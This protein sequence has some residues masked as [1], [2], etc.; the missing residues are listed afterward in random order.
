MPLVPQKSRQDGTIYIGIDP[1][2]SGGIVLIDG[3]NIYVEPMPTTEQDTWQ[4]IQGIG[5]RHGKVLDKVSRS[6][7]PWY[8]ARHAVIEWIHPAIQGIGKSQMS[9]L[10]GNYMALRMALTACSI[11]FDVVMP[12]KWQAALNIQSRK[13]GEATNKWKDRLRAKAQQLH[14]GLECWKWNLGEQRKVSD[15]VLIADYCRRTFNG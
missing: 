6:V 13:K 3:R 7:E 15:A 1:G 2:A 12:K 9:K 14:P 5:Y 8:V 4:L 10:Y 11:P